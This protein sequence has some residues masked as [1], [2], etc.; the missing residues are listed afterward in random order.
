M[1]H[2][3]RSIDVF[4][5]NLGCTFVS[6]MIKTNHSTPLILI[7]IQRICK[8]NMCKF[9]EMMQFS[10]LYVKFTRKNRSFHIAKWLMNCV[11][12]QQKFYKWNSI[13]CNWIEFW[14]NKGVSKAYNV[15][16]LTRYTKYTEKLFVIMKMNI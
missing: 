6:H 10:F 3:N 16:P 7:I 13:E 1:C 11:V 14:S 4:T 5:L 2:V 15:I 12:Q 8:S 9:A